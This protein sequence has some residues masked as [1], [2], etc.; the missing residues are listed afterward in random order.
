MKEPGLK[1]FDPALCISSQARENINR[2]RK[3]VL[4]P[5]R[6]YWKHGYSFL[7]REDD[8]D[9]EKKMASSEDP[10]ESLLK[11]FTRT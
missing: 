8:P 7:V 2:L 3:E 6:T 5:T 4:V 11:A 9:F 10:P 1:E